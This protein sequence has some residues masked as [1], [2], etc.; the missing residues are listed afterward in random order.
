MKCPDLDKRIAS[1]VETELR[2][3]GADNSDYF[4]VWLETY[5][6]IANEFAHVAGG[7]NECRENV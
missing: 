1:M 4:E 7:H 3:Y 5:R 6:Q 2:G